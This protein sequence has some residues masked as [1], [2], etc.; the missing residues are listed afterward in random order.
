MK[1][2]FRLLFLLILLVLLV[3]CEENPIENDEN[4]VCV[5][6]DGNIYD[7]VQI[8]NQTWINSNLRVVHYED[9][10]KIAN[11]TTD[12]NWINDY[13]G[14]YCVYDNNESYVDTY[15]YLYNWYAVNT[16]LLAPE[17]W[18]VPTDTEWIEL[19]MVLGMSESEADSMGF[20]GTNQGSQ[21]AGNTGLWIYGNFANDPEFG[22][23]GFNALPGG[24]RNSGSGYYG[25]MYN[26][27]YFWSSTENND[28]HAWVRQVHY[29]YL[30]VSRYDN[31][32][33]YGHSV[34]LVKDN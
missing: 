18:H 20:R 26:G 23:S 33:Q 3:N 12:D 24:Y 5:D 9:G 1:T 17:G 4:L 2:M 22:T 11:L 30:G 10:S 25:R 16:G 8:G 13:K 32:K 31:S 6:Y 29:L 19:E 15:G 7:T 21:L 27:G 28:V 14:A 34:R